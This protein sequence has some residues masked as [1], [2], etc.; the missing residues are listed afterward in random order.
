[1]PIL[2]LGKF[3]FSCFTF[4][5]LA[6]LN[7]KLHAEDLSES[8]CYPDLE[9]I[10]KLDSVDGEVQNTNAAL[11]ADES[12]MAILIESNQVS[13]DAL[14][15][16][17]FDGNVVIKNGDSQIRANSARV[18]KQTQQITADGG[19]EFVHPNVKVVSESFQADIDDSSIELL[20]TKYTLADSAGHGEAELLKMSGGYESVVLT[21]ATFTSCPDEEKPDWKLSASEI[22]LSAEG[23]GGEAWHTPFMIKDVPILYVPYFTFPLTDRR[24]SGFLLPK[25]DS[26]KNDGLD[27]SLPFYWNIAEN[28]DATITTRTMSNRGILLGT[29]F[30][31]LNSLGQGAIYGEYIDRDSAYLNDDKRHALSINYQGRIAN[32]WKT[33]I[34]LNKVSDDSYI[35]DLGFIDFN[36]V[37][38]HIESSMSFYKYSDNGFI[39]INFRHFDV[40]GDHDLP[41]SALPEILAEYN[42]DFAD[43]SF[44]FFMPMEA[45]YFDARENDD[46]DAFRLHLE[47]TVKWQWIEPA[48]ELAAETSFLA[49][50]YKQENLATGH[51]ETLTRA[52]PRARINAQMNLERPVMWFGK[53]MTQTL[54]P[55]AQFLWVPHREQSDIGLYD[56]T[57]LQDDFYGLFR[58][59]RLSGIDRILESNSLT[60]GMTSRMINRFNQEKFQVSLGQIF[61]LDNSNT[62]NI[63]Q[64]FET[65]RGESAIALDL[66]F[67]MRERWFLHYGLQYDT[68]LERTR[69]SHVTLD[70]RFDEANFVQLSHRFVRDVSSS[71][72][73]TSGIGS[74]I[75]MSGIMGRFELDENWQIF[76][77]YFRDFE[78]SRELESRIGMIYQSCCWAIQLAYQSHIMSDLSSLNTQQNNNV[79]AITDEGIVF[80]FTI[81]R[82]GA[83]KVSH[84]KVLEDGVFGYRRSYFLNQ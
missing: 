68:E 51:F 48:W 82:F 30:R 57:L 20:K 37:D 74:K 69:K 39:D 44:S 43:P 58:V 11:K 18:D 14:K 64:A 35:S 5:L 17:S 38:T 71:K 33:T 81:G 67:D 13:M 22:L 19:I 49:T 53:E 23:E 32:G 47:P 83:G 10:K 78:L 41:Y 65:P 9:R 24:K 12:K 25:I 50:A 6:M 34:D 46:S 76:G 61:Y 42:F 40:F 8:A 28:Y 84:T 72:I 52:M 3:S 16:A 15:L 60:L 59:N 45:A 70:Y 56:T 21:D 4:I 7:S 62:D 66:D 54:E 26:S 63:D 31:F 79:S 75:N 55:K 29:E 77:N 36:R 1:M 27:I 73:N 80:R 2:S